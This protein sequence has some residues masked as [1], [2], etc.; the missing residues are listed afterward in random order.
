MELI[1]L[2]DITKTYHLGE[3]DVPVLKGVS[4]SIAR[5]EMVALMGALRLRQDHAD[6]HPRLPRSA[7][8]GG[9][10]WLDG[11]EMSRLECRTSGRWCGRRKSA[12][13]SRAS[14]CCRGPRPRRTSSC[15]WT[16]P[17]G[18]MA[19]P[20]RGGWPELLLE[21][22][23]LA[24]RCD[25]EPSQ[26]SGG[27]QQRVAIARALVNRPALVLADEPTG[28]LDSH[29]SVEILRMF[30]QLN[31][32]GITVILVTHDPK[33]AAYRP[34]HDPHRGRTDRGRR[35][36][37]ASRG[38][39]APGLRPACRPILAG[40]RRKATPAMAAPP[41]EA[42]PMEAP[43]TEAPPTAA[44]PTAA[45]PTAAW[46]SPAS[47]PDGHWPPPRSMRPALTATATEF[48]T[49]PVWPRSKRR[50]PPRATGAIDGRPSSADR[51][52]P[53][54]AAESAQNGAA[55]AEDLPNRAGSV[56]AG[57]RGGFLVW[58]SRAAR[59][60]FWRR[61]S[62][63]HH[64]PHGAG[65][66][67]GQ[68]AAL[69]FDGAGGHHRRGG[70][71]RHDRNRPRLENRDPKDDRQ[72][73]RQQSAGPA[74]LAPAGSVSFGSGTVQTLKPNDMDEILRQ[75]PA[76]LDVAPI[77]WTRAQVVYGSRNWIPRTMDGTSPA[78]L[79]VRDWNDMEEGDMFT[80]HDVQAATSVCVIGTT[81]ETGE[82]FDDDIAG[83]QG[84][85]HSQRPVPGRR[86][87]Q[88][89]GSQYDGL[90]PRRH[91]PRPLDD[92]QIPVNGSGAGNTTAEAAAEQQSL[93]RH[94]H[95]QQPLS[96]Q[97]QPVRRAFECP[98]RR[99][100]PIHPRRSIST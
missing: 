73:G 98:N 4:L 89:Q 78:Y 83:R 76:V 59:R 46:P 88:Q 84:C 39:R 82:L 90:R 42:P 22:V 81:L 43:P 13:S 56:A 45:P 71:D 66:V 26:M 49:S 32:E 70:R 40:D 8:F 86:R 24:E 96:R 65:C 5:G 80:D 20:N 37:R 97:R 11:Q 14:I 50:R 21:R 60:P 93:D 48:A 61:I 35:S 23:G 17:A 77:V 72:H 53:P 29:T 34:S 38:G 28:N 55:E 2:E 100:P 19:E 7:Q 95:A 52:H 85:P 36:R 16:I 9:R 58:P 25:H 51:T 12:S 68:Q 75:C 62:A 44:P 15:P 27:Q 31:A 74:R 91:P 67:A 41:M 33:V 57:R 10:F 94:Q 87:A 6:E 18:G 54:S 69:G 99:R 79:R 92:H 3:V 64:A 63:P 30:Q 1:R 47:P